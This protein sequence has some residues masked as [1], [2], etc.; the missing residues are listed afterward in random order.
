MASQFS[1][2]RG[3]QDPFMHFSPGHFPFPIE[4]SEFAPREAFYKEKIRHGDDTFPIGVHRTLGTDNC[5]IA[6][7]LH[8]HEEFEF[9]VVTEGRA[10]FQVEGIKVEVCQGEGIFINSNLLHMG[11]SINGEKCSHFAVV[12]HPIFLSGYSNSCINQNYINPILNCSLSFPIHFRP[13]VSWQNEVLMLLYE[14]FAV[15]SDNLQ[16]YE[17][18]IKSKM[19]L[20]WYLCL[21]NAVVNSATAAE[22]NYK[23]E[24]LKSVL[25]YISEHYSQKISLSELARTVH[26]SNEHFCRF[27]KEVTR[28]SP[29][30]YLN[31]Y[32]VQKSCDLLLQTDMGITE[33]ATTAGFETISYYNK[34]FK[35]IMTCTPGRFRKSNSYTLPTLENVSSQSRR[36]Q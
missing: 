27:F 18:L 32:R 24:R 17:M 31:M 11:H 20:V 4:A 34:V 14:T 7:Y 12:F 10:I 21:K 8:W 6:L 35:S 30:T 25:H 13:D 5:D 3:A 33:I 36:S 29:F 26:M 19:Y 15:H 23:L 22:S 2:T 28:Y 1:K 16:G 9:L